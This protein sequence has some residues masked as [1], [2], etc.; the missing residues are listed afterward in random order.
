MKGQKI[1]ALS[2]VSGDTIIKVD[3]TGGLGMFSCL[4][5]A[6]RG[7]YAR[8]PCSVAI[9]GRSLEAPAIYG[10]SINSTGLLGQ[11]SGG[12]GVYGMASSGYGGTFEGGSGDIQLKG[13]TGS[14]VTDEFDSGSSFLFRA[15]QDINM[16]L[17]YLN[18]VNGG[19]FRIKKGTSSIFVVDESGTI[20]FDGAIHSYGDVIAKLDINNNGSNRFRV[21]NGSNTTVFSVN[22]SG[23]VELGGPLESYGDIDFKIDLNNNGSHEFNIRNGT[24]NSVFSVDE[25][26]TVRVL[27]S[28]V[29]SSDRNLKDHIQEIDLDDIL[30]KIDDLPIYSW[31]YKKTEPLHI[32]PMSQDFYNTFGLGK[33]DKGIATVDG[34][35]IAIAG[36]KA[37]IS[38]NEQLE[39]RIEQLEEELEELKSIV[40]KLVK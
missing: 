35:G 2:T 8:S 37:L 21:R 11:T 23:T 38:E 19:E 15:N 28:I 26:G 34:D 22:E 6:G 12:F 30:K 13:A 24:S 29:H 7:I 14:I 17:N 3:H 10:Y 4:G 33:D 32:G 9:E 39:N 31:K 36:V 5:H 20:K 25:A 16:E 27:G 40:A 1:D 18:N